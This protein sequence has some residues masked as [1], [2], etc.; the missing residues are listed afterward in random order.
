MYLK[1]DVLSLTD[2]FETFIKTCLEY[3]KLYPCHYFNLPGLSWDA[4][5]KMTG[6]KLDLISDNDIHLLIKK[7]IKSEVSYIAKR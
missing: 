7:G 5:L 1:A 3:Y 6:V 2:V 4:M